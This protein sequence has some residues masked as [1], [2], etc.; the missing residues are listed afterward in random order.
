MK[1]G[2]DLRGAKKK[3]A[4]K[5]AYESAFRHARN[6]DQ[7]TTAARKLEALGE[8]VSIQAHLGFVTDW[9]LIGPF[10]AAGMS[11]FRTPFPPETAVNLGLIAQTADKK[12]LRWI[13]HQT[14][15]PFGTVDLVQVLGPVNEAVGYA[16]TEIDSPGS[17]EAQLRC[18]R[19]RLPGRL[20]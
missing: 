4:A 18:K 20:A 16:Y 3:T 15:D 2:D 19:G 8:K 17:H 11:G 14:A 9:S 13:H 5:Q 1:R 12:E 7:V 10:P 6:V